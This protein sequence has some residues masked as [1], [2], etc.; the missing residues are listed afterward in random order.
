MT[1]PVVLVHGIRVSRTM[2]DP[3][4]TALDRPALAV[5]L[6]GH[7]T[8][9]GDAFTL[10]AATQTVAAAVDRVGGRALLA[11]LSLGGYVGITAAAR[12]P[13]R[14]AGLVAMGCTSRSTHLARLYRTAAALAARFPEQ[15][16]RFS[17]YAFR[18][19]LPRPAA[20]AVV[21][22]GFSCEA[23][24]AVVA[25]L[26]AHNHLAALA[27]YPGPVWLVNG[28]RDPFRGDERAFL[29]ACRDGHLIRLPRTGHVTTLADPVRLARLLDDAAS[30]VEQRRPA[31]C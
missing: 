28:D 2:W 29:D 5:D 12:F 9:R 23:L 27:A 1:L 20:D 15:A 17:A 10:A 22:G 3:V 31:Q 26:T 13:D 6:P 19:A 11:G 16:N 30:Q 24:P 4:V 14:V 8:R 25:A 21:A 18:R 7:G